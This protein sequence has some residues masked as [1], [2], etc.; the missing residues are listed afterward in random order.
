M[1]YLEVRQTKLKGR[2]V[3]TT[4]D[5]SQGEIIEVCPI[6][7]LPEGDTPHIDVTK[8][9]NYYFNW[10][11]KLNKVAIALGYGSLYNHSYT[12]NAVYEKDF[13]RNLLV[14]RSLSDIQAGEEITVNYNGTP[15]DRRPLWFT[16]SD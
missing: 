6:I 13:S 9:Y 15:T 5:I 1:D 8:L 3:F 12:P 7:E 10:G 14:F 2:G 16:P 4:R 11:E